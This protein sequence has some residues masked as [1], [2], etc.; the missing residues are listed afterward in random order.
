MGAR[1]VG[2][3]AELCEICPPDIS[4]ITGIC[5]QHME[6]FGTFA[7]VVK[8]KGEILAYTKESAI[9]A[10]DCY[11]LFAEYPV[12]I[13]KCLCASDSDDSPLH[14]SAA[15]LRPLLREHPPPDHFH[16]RHIYPPAYRG[17]PLRNPPDCKI[18]FYA[19]SQKNGFLRTYKLV[20]ILIW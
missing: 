9:T 19:M 12:R 2:D 14:P 15:K 4:L 7:N 18:F 6:T 1:H 3:I 13:K 8:A 11:E 5:G 10:A 20:Y 16:K 17:L